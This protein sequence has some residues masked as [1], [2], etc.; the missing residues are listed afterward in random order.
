MSIRH[1]ASLLCTNLLRAPRKNFKQGSIWIDTGCVNFAG[2][3]LFGD[4]L[5]SLHRRYFQFPDFQNFN[6]VQ[7]KHLY[8]NISPFSR[9]SRARKV[10]FER[11]KVQKF[12]L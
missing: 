7:K 6:K 1:G 12:T 3:I 8:A 4:R 5:F 9:H 2:T 11:H 10:Y